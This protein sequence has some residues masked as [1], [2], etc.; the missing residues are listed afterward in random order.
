MVL[1]SMVSSVNSLQAA[2]AS[3]IVADKTSVKAHLPNSLLSFVTRVNCKHRWITSRT[4]YPFMFGSGTNWFTQ[5]LIRHRAS[6]NALTLVENILR[7]FRPRFVY[8]NFDGH[9]SVTAN[10]CPCCL[11]QVNHPWR[12]P[13]FY[14]WRKIIFSFGPI[15]WSVWVPLGPP[16]KHIHGNKASTLVES[17]LPKWTSHFGSI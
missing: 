7:S 3:A 4:I 9:N 2:K 10:S 17:R 16:Q 14:D 8:L 1:V 6:K 5:A 15:L 13:A 12:F 11:P